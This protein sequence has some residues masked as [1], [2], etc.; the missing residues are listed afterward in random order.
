MVDT[1]L[2]IASLLDRWMHQHFGRPYTAL[3]SIALVL[4]IIESFSKLVGEIAASNH[5]SIWRIVAVVGFQAAL[6]INQ[7]AQLAE[8]RDQRRAARAV[9]KAGADVAAPTARDIP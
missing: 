8:Q 5:I 7:L 2:R 3:L 4:G 6:L 1:I 9:R